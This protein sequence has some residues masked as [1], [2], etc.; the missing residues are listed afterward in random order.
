MENEFAKKLEERIK[1]LYSSLIEKT[2]V[3]SYP[4]AFFCIQWGKLYPKMNNTGIL[5][6]G[7]ATNGWI[8]DLENIDIL[9]GDSEYSIFN[10]KDQMQWVE[11][12]EGNIHG[13]NTRKSAF[14]RVIKNISKSFYPENWSAHVAWSNICKVA[15]FEQGNPSDS[16]YYVQIELCNQILGIEIEL[17]SPEIIVLFTGESWAKDFLYY[18]THEESPQAIKC[19]HWGKENQF[20]MKAYLI[21][22]RIYIQTE[23]PQGRKEDLHIQTII[24]TINELK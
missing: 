17:L 11:D 13:Y 6:I 12:C 20:T 23:H 7:R 9:F 14:W 22:G 1:P 21:N 19:K 3:F 10:R 18:L 5:F 15:P 8:T 4:K 24:E 16:L 2:K